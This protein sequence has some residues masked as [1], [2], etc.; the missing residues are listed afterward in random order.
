METNQV[1]KCAGYECKCEKVLGVVTKLVVVRPV[2]VSGG[3]ERSGTQCKS[4]EK[5]I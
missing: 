5:R 1:E 3:Y 2:I 4:S